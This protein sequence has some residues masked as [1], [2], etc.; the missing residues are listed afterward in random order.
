MTVVA[1]PREVGAVAEGNLPTCPLCGNDSYEREE[2]RTDSKWGL[3]SHVKILLI[4][5]RCRYV[6]T[7]YDYNSIFDFN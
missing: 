5:D 1:D 6:L 2:E 7:F 3:T 4:C